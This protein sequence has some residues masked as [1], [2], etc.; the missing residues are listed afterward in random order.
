MIEITECEPTPYIKEQFYHD[1][2]G[3]AC[4]CYH[5]TDG[6]LWVVARAGSH[7]KDRDGLWIVHPHRDGPYSDR[8]WHREWP[9]GAAQ[10]VEEMLTSCGYSI[11]PHRKHRRLHVPMF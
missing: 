2:G 8:L 7:R 4:T 9:N 10:T 11:V 5:Y 3:G 1:A 6:T